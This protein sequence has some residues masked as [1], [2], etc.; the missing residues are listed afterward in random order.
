MFKVEF[1]LVWVLWGRKRCDKD[2]IS[3]ISAIIRP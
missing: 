1:V 2:N 3:R